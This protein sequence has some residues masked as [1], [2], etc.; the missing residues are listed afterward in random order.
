[1]H[2]EVTYIGLHKW[3]K[4]AFEHLG[5]MVLAQHHGHFDKVAVYVASLGRLSQAINDKIKET[6]DSDKKKDLQILK[7]QVNYL[8]VFVG[9]NLST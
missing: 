7:N 1:M 3:T 5:W 4:H 6:K 8:S 9:R 2:E